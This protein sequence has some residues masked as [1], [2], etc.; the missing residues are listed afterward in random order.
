M[1]R[2]LIIGRA[3]RQRLELADLALDRDWSVIADA[4]RLRQILVNLLTN[5][6]KFTRAGG[7][8]GIDVAPGPAGIVL[9]AVWD[10]GIGIPAD[11]LERVF[12]S[13]HQVSSGMLDTASD[14]VG[15]GLSISRQFARLMGGDLTAESTVG[16][17]SRFTLRLP[18]APADPAGR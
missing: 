9:I 13:F 12:E 18:L 11:Q 3:E 2:A 6:V 1:A 4:G 10:S 16:R 17:G 15:L 8:I 5:A 7:R 14:G